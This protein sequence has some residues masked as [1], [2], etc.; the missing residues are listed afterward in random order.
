[1]GEAAYSHN[2]A[3]AGHHLTLCASLLCDLSGSFG[4]NTSLVLDPALYT[5]PGVYRRC[6]LIKSLDPPYSTGKWRLPQ[7]AFSRVTA[8]IL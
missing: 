4:N 5:H 2:H 7:D 3:A 8:R 1:M 6:R